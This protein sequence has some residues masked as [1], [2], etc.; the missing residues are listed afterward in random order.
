[1]L[2]GASTKLLDNVANPK[3]TAPMRILVVEDQAKMSAF[4]KRGLMEV[5]YA[6]DVAE[7]GQAAEALVAESEYDLIVMDVMLPDQNGIDTSRHIRRDGYVGPI[8]M[9]TALSTTR[10]K[11]NGLDLLVPSSVPA[12]QNLV[13]ANSALS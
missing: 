12:L 6:V 13:S 3:K 7:S 4:L 8:L 1:M 2:G 10:D 11:V 9:L 5:G